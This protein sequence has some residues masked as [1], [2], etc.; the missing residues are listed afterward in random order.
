[1]D[2]IKYESAQ[3]DLIRLEDVDIVTDS[4]V[5]GDGSPNYDEGAWT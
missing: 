4:T 1:M 5:L 3:L 2:K